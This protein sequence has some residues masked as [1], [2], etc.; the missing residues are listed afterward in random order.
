VTNPGAGVLVISSLMASGDFGQ[1]NNCPTG[2]APGASCTVS[3]TFTPSTGGGRT[4]AITFTDNAAGSPQV[5]V[6]SGSGGAEAGAGFS[7]T[8]VLFGNQDVNTTPAAQT[9]AL[10]NTGHAA[11]AVPAVAVR[12]NNPGDRAK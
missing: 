8:S 5:I 9:V 2:L 4:G 1:T 10:T 12:G 11:L 3:V 7:T 6:L